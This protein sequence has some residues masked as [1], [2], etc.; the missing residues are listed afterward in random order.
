MY[1]RSRYTLQ[2]QQDGALYLQ[3]TF[4]GRG[5]IYPAEALGLLKGRDGPPEVQ[6][7]LIQ[8]GHLV[9]QHADE[10]ARGQ[11]QQLVGLNKSDVLHLIL[12]PTEKCNFRCVYC[13]ERF[14][15]GVMTPP[16]RQAVRSL[17]AQQAPSLKALK[18]SWFGGEPLIAHQVMVEL[19]EFFTEVAA[20]HRLKYAAHATTN[21]SLLTPERAAQYAALGL[22]DY[23]ITLDGPAHFHDQKRKLLGGGATFETIWRNLTA[24]QAQTLDFR[25]QLRINL[26]K[27]NLAIASGFVTTL[28]EQFGH[29][30]RFQLHVH[31]VER[32]GARMTVRSRCSTLHIH[33]SL[34]SMHRAPLV[35]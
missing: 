29:D 25:V 31:P 19:S 32:W 33:P 24:L 26:D 5:G 34:P 11:A 1:K 30:R 7:R 13:Y 21:G 14:E 17:V 27:E 16:V 10:L 4:T 6:A 12:M 18:I 35:G 15:H 23:Q 9:P 22:R 3:N 20:Q 2:R 28:G 8:E